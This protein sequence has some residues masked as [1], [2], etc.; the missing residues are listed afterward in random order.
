MKIVNYRAILSSLLLSALICALFISS[1]AAQQ[2]ASPAKPAN[3]AQAAAQKP[4][5][6]PPVNPALEKVIGDQPDT[7]QAIQIISQG[8][9][10]STR[11][12]FARK[13]DLQRLEF[14][15]GNTP[16]VMIG[17]PDLKKNFTMR[18]DNKVFS[19]APHTDILGP[20]L[21]PF[22]L[23]YLRTYASRNI[24]IEDLGS[25]NINGHNC[26]KYRLSFDQANN[27]ETITVWKAPDLNNLIIRQ[28]MEFLNIKSSVELQ[29][30]QLSVT[31]DLFQLPKDYQQART[32]RDMFQRATA[33]P[34]A[35]QPTKQ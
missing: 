7:L 17:R 6:T 8:G 31:D 22:N 23:R 33:Q 19:E 13:G 11:V 3:N 4:K 20:R 35:A 9:A 14:S 34:Q 2:S 21:D 15:Q 24:K 5:P 29:N 10:S 27:V 26:N 1:V 18:A 25:E 30:I 12:T 28:E 32:N 16:I